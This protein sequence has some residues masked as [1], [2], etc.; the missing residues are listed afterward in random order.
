M[1]VGANVVGQNVHR[2]GGII[3]GAIVGG[4]FEPTCTAR[5]DRHRELIDRISEAVE[6]SDD[7]CVGRSHKSISASVEPD[8]LGM[9]RVAEAKS[10][11]EATHWIKFADL[12]GIE[13]R[14]VEVLCAVERGA[15]I[16]AVYPRGYQLRQQ[17]SSERVIDVY[18][19]VIDGK[20][21]GTWR[22]G[23]WC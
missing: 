23:C 6:L 14:H 12:E 19:L 13:I 3:N 16:D 20:E 15:G 10:F 17:V 21:Y 22:Y 8:R 18:G 4:D 7:I 2:L 5:L 11:R 9:P 1:R